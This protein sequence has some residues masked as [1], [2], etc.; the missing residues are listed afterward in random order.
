MTRPSGEPIDVRPGGRSPRACLPVLLCLF[1]SD[2][3]A[4]AAGR[5]EEWRGLRPPPAS[6]KAP[7]AAAR[8]APAAVCGDSLLDAGETCDDGNVA[9]GDGCSSSCQVEP[10]FD[11]TAPVPPTTGN[12]VADGSFEAGTPNPSWAEYSLQFGTPLCDF[13]SCS[14]NGASDGAWWLWFGGIDE[15]E[16]ASVEQ[17]VTIPPSAT[18]LT[19]DLFGTRCDSNAD[20]LSV[21][22]DGSEV[23]RFNCTLT[24]GYTTRS[25]AT[26]P[27]ADGLSHSLRFEATT[28]A[29]NG[30]HSNLFVDRIVLDDHTGG[31]PPIPSQCSPSPPLCQGFDFGAA[32]G[33]L[34]GW[35]LF[36]AAS[37]LA[38]DWGTTDD[39]FCWSNTPD[40]VPASNVTGGGGPAACADSDAAGLGVVDAYLCSPLLAGGAAV[41]PELRFRYNYQLFGVPGPDDRFEVLVGTEPPG[42]GTIGG[43]ATVFS[44][45]GNHG[46]L[47]ALPGDGERIAL[48]AQDFHACFRYGGNF[49]WYA[50]LDDVEL[51]AASCFLDG[52]GDGVTDTQ[53]N[54]TLA[55]NPDQRDTDGDGIGSVCDGDF[56]QNCIVQF[57]DLGLMKAG[58]FGTDPNLDM[59]GNGFVQFPDLALLKQGFFLPPGPSGVP[60][61]CSAR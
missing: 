10:G 24:P 11:C 61:P 37:A 46:A 15:F 9:S 53:D 32:A 58:F 48:A 3:A 20:F 16:E 40:Q 54:C 21:Q 34:G 39:G 13:A 2:P 27:F 38:V 22:I 30:G 6:S 28:F 44:T 17:T 41:E 26:G 50:Q 18:T 4:A 45:A 42:A 59:D 1:A 35:T 8:A 33:D 23:F 60:N 49:D 51:R 25:V 31:D 19:F 47:L 12:V 14:I 5:F 52:D 55:A 43:Y 29:N 56:D 36:H 57:P 7:A